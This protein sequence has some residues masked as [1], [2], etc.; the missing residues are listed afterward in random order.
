MDYMNRR[1]ASKL[2]ALG[3]A[4]EDT[5]SESIL[6]FAICYGTV[7]MITVL[8]ILESEWNEYTKRARNIDRESSTSSN[9]RTTVAMPTRKPSISE[10]DLN[11]PSFYEHLV[12]SPVFS[13]H[14]TLRKYKG[15]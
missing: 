6:H 9:V 11:S 3:V 14:S 12:Q 10:S 5:A 8:W 15:Q 2:G 1:Y 7:G 4:D 13:S